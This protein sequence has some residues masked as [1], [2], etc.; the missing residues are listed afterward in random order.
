MEKVQEGRAIFGL[1]P[2][3]DSTREEYRKWKE[4]RERK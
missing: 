2:P 4:A 3:A 1:Y